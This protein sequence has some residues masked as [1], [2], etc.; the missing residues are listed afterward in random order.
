[1]NFFTKDELEVFKANILQNNQNVTEEELSLITKNEF[2]IWLEE[3]KIELKDQIEKNTLLDP[4]LKEQRLKNAKHDFLYFVKTYF[5]HYFSIKSQCALHITLA[6]DFVKYKAGTKLAYAAPRGHAKTT[7][8]SKLYPLYLICFKLKKF[9]IEVSDAVELVQSN[10]EAIKCEL[11][12]NANLKAD[13]PE[14]CGISK[15]WKVGEFITNNG[16]KLK[17]FGSSK[18]LRGITYGAYRPDVVILDDLEND[19]NVRSKEQRNKLEDWLDE[20]VLNLGNVDGTLLV[21]YIG[22]ILHSDSVLARKLKLSYWNPKRFASVIKFPKRMDLWEEYCNI[23]KKNGLE[24]AR[25]FYTKQKSIM[26]DGSEVLWP[27]AMTLDAL[28]RKRA[29]NLKA[30]NKE[31]MNAPLIEN[32]KFKLDLIKYYKGEPKIDYSVMYIDPAG[33]SKKSDFTSLTVLGVNKSLRKCYVLKSIIKILPA[34]AIIKNILE[35]QNKFRCKLVAI[36]TNGG[37]FFLKSWTLEAAFDA[38]IFLPLRGVNNY[39]SKSERIETLELPI[40]NGEILFNIESPLLIEQL[41]EYPQ[42]NNDDGPDSLAGAYALIKINNVKRRKKSI[43]KRHGTYAF[44]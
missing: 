10:L 21:F 5:P 9:I 30:F 37:Q 14:A 27:E 42:G 1:M 32:Q 38:N 35:L 26:D 29:E 11:E 6:N 15:N 13:F 28:M 18:R 39:K 22:T 44:F 7:F 31:Q 33:N 43:R 16:V 34:K 23:Y 12:Y 8:T 25:K 24:S 41:L 17:A 3:L 4:S 40:E 2:K 20:A 19:I 36:E